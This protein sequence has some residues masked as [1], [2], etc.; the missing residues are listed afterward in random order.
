MRDTTLDPDDFVDQ[1]TVTYA[2]FVI[3][4]GA[5]VSAASLVYGAD[6]ISFLESG[7]GDPWAIRIHEG[8]H[9]A[10]Q[11]LPISDQAVRHVL[12]TLADTSELAEFDWTA[13]TWTEFE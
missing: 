6:G 5:S 11:P 10:G 2:E 4:P 3:I 9:F 12:E 8:Y 13:Q 7:Y 1:D